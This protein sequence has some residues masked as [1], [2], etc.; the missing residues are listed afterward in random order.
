M[1]PGS[2]NSTLPGFEIEI[3]RPSTRTTSAVFLLRPAIS[4]QRIPYGFGDA[5]LVVA[6]LGS[7]GAQEPWKAIVNAR[8]PHRGGWRRTW[9]S[10]V[11]GDHRRGHA[12]SPVA[13]AIRRDAGWLRTHRSDGGEILAHAG[14]AQAQSKRPAR[15]QPADAGAARS[16]CC[17]GRRRPPES[18]PRRRAEGPRGLAALLRAAGRY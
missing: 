10:A 9:T 6:Y 14:I 4:W 16:S 5:A 11:S 2:G 15:R 13:A 7:T 3:S 8:E 18:A 12:R 1:Y 17:T